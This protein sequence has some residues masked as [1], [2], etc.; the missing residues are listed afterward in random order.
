M[1]SNTDSHGVPDERSSTAPVYDGQSP[2]AVRPMVNI[3]G[4][5]RASRRHNPPLML[6]AGVPLQRAIAR[7]QQ[8]TQS[9][10]VTSVM[11]QTTVRGC[12]ADQHEA[13][14]TGLDFS[15]PFTDS[16]PSRSYAL[17]RQ[18]LVSP[19]TRVRSPSSASD[20]SSD[21]ED[22]IPAH[23]GSSSKFL[24]LNVRRSKQAQLI[25]QNEVALQ[26][27]SLRHR[28]AI[29]QAQPTQQPQTVPQEAHP[30][31]QH[32]PVNSQ[33]ADVVGTTQVQYDHGR[34]QADFPPLTQ[35]NPRGSATFVP[36]S[37]Q[38]GSFAQS[39]PSHIAQAPFSQ[40]RNETSGT[41]RSQFNSVQGEIHPATS[42]Q[43][44][45]QASASC[46]P[47]P[48][49]HGPVTGRPLYQVQQPYAQQQHAFTGAVGP[50]SDSYQIG[51]QPATHKEFDPRASASFYPESLQQN[52]PTR[53]V[54]LQ[55]ARVST[56]YEDMARV[57]KK[58]RRY[59]NSRT[60]GKN[61]LGQS[62]PSDEQLDSEPDE[63]GPRG[64]DQAEF[65]LQTP[66]DPGKEEATGTSISDHLTDF[67]SHAEAKVFALQY[68]VPEKSG[69]CFISEPLSRE[70]KATSHLM[71]DMLRIETV[72]LDPY[73]LPFST[74]WTDVKI[75]YGISRPPMMPRPGEFI[76]DTF[77]RLMDRCGWNWTHVK[78][79]EEFTR[80]VKFEVFRTLMANPNLLHPG[81]TYPPRTPEQYHYRIRK[82]CECIQGPEEIERLGPLN[83]FSRL[84]NC[85]Q[86]LK[87]VH[88]NVYDLIRALALTCHPTTFPSAEDL[89]G[90]SIWNNR[91]FYYHFIEHLPYDNILGILLKYPRR[92]TDGETESDHMA[93]DYVAAHKSYK[94]SVA[95]R[96]MSKRFPGKFGRPCGGRRSIQIKTQTQPARPLGMNTIPSVTPGPSSQV[97]ATVPP[98]YPTGYSLPPSQ[99]FS[100]SH[101]PVP[102]QPYST[103]YA[104]QPLNPYTAVSAPHTGQAVSSTL[105][106]SATPYFTPGNIP[107]GPANPKPSKRSEYRHRS[108]KK[109]YNTPPSGPNPSLPPDITESN[110]PALPA[111][112]SPDTITE[113]HQ[114][115][116]SEGDSETA[117][118]QDKGK[119]IAGTGVMTAADGTDF[120]VKASKKNGRKGSN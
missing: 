105:N 8:N 70:D 102:V 5:S 30:A 10:P 92:E 45:P 75:R 38:H 43:L 119:G 73:G 24:P 3:P 83:D 12:A 46:H 84:E 16:Q 66:S 65:H 27:E 97:S 71:K 86:F 34:V 87:N 118:G 49:H 103:G 107:T 77:R 2:N 99:S 7:N 52:V 93:A 1:S 15:D 17:R 79:K 51:P 6:S 36:G 50:Q 13:P 78:T 22:P 74:Y 40:E 42:M 57:W 28:Q 63:S 25:Q 94:G 23:H 96:H 72:D 21:D 115:G 33:A 44:N 29:Q 104:S 116:S 68:R 39:P 35:L 112:T 64:S 109:R 69:S 20:I 11:N 106:P 101:A 18:S 19:T 54:S 111:S 47:G 113:Q 76:Y 60:I 90:N 110:F 67:V 81:T 95:H 41:A 85:K 117:T 55:D 48:L 37:F 4:T 89:R 62:G 53:T 9:Q 108:E 88:V 59:K 98:P 82:I 61:I 120:T 91:R 58:P 14:Q 31:Q 56:T 80:C 114:R 100:T 32:R 26:Q